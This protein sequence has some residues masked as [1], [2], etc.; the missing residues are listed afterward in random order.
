ME[1][2]VEVVAVMMR[3]TDIAETVREVAETAQIEQIRQIMGMD[4]EGTMSDDDGMGAEV[5]AE[6]F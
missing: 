4:G 5:T 3:T 2:E 6:G 1:T